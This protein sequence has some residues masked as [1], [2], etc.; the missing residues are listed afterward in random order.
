MLKN[1]VKQSFLLAAGA[2]AGMLFV[3]LLPYAWAIAGLIVIAK[4]LA[5]RLV[6]AAER[7]AGFGWRPLQSYLTGRKS[8]KTVK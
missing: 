4:V 2:L 1:V 5:E 8:K 6:L 3:L 7:N